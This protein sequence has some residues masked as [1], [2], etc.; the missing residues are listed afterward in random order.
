MVFGIGILCYLPIPKTL[1]YQRIT[2]CFI[3]DSKTKCNIEEATL[4]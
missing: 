2:I 4:L 3:V 1:L